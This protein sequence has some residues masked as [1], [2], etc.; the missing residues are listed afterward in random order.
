MAREVE[1]RVRYFETDR[2][3]YA[4]HIHYFRWFEIG[5]AELLRDAGLPLTL[6]EMGLALVLAEVGC[7]YKAPAKYDDLLQVRTR[8]VE[9]RPKVVRYEY[10]VQRGDALLAEGFTVHVCTDGKG[11]SIEMPPDVLE[12]LKAHVGK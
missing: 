6:E 4:N 3:G 2:M 10:S 5:R 8:I 9:V 11:R 1:V 7:R 12:K